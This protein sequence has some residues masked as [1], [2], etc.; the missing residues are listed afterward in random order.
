MEN[1]IFFA[2]LPTFE[3]HF[4]SQGSEYA[5]ADYTETG[6][7]KRKYTCILSLFAFTEIRQLTRKEKLNLC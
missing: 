1:S 4:T 2:V 7:V 6:S 5:C 3:N